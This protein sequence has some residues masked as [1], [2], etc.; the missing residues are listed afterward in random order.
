MDAN[1]TSELL[2]SYIRKSNLNFNIVESPFSLTVTIK[3]SFIKNKNG[4]LRHSGLDSNTT[5]AKQH[6]FP[7]WYQHS[8]VNLSS[9]NQHNN[10]ENTFAEHNVHFYQDTFHPK[11]SQDDLFKNPVKV[12]QFLPVQPSFYSNLQPPSILNFKKENSVLLPR[13]SLLSQQMSGTSPTL[14]VSPPATSPSCTVPPP[15]AKTPLPTPPPG[16]TATAVPQSTPASSPSYTP[17]GLPPGFELGKT[18][19]PPSPPPGATAASKLPPL[20]PSSQVPGIRSTTMA[21]RSPTYQKLIDD[22][23]KFSE[24]KPGEDIETML[25]KLEA[26]K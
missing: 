14:S 12:N 17:P 19:P 24:T 20:T 11:T 10:T 2:L 6:S 25:F 9:S 18:F 1:Q 7:S 13:I 15:P 16:S 23:V 22:I 5:S 4:S 26:L 21:P 8:K 3:K